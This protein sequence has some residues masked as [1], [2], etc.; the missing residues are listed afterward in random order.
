M[1]DTREPNQILQRA[2]RALDGLPNIHS[3][4]AWT[5]NGHEKRWYL[6]ISIRHGLPATTNIP[7]ITNWIVVPE[8]EFIESG[9]EVYPAING[10]IEAT[11]PHQRYNTVDKENGRRTGRP[12]LTRPSHTLKRMAE[13]NWN[14]E[15]EKFIWRICRLVDW[16]IDAANN[17]LINKSDPFELPDFHGAE[18]CPLTL[19]F[20]EDSIS[21]DFWKKYF[22]SYGTVNLLIHNKTLLLKTFEHQAFISHSNE[23]D[24]IEPNFSYHGKA[25]WVLLKDI[26]ILDPW[27]AP[28][29]FG[30]LR[31][32]LALS[33]LDLENIISKFSNRDFRSFRNGKPLL[34]IIGFPIPEKIG[35]KPSTIHWQA[36]FLPELTTEKQKGFRKESLSLRDKQLCFKNDSQVAWLRSE[37]WTKNNL[38][39]RG[40]LPE[41]MRQKK[42]TIIGAGS[43]G[44]TFTE[45]LVRAGF[46][47]LILVDGDKFRASNASRHVLNLGHVGKPKVEALK[48]RLELIRPGIEIKTYYSFITAIDKSGLEDINSS[49]FIIDITGNSEVLAWADRSLKKSDSLFISLSFGYAAQK[50]FC[51]VSESQNLDVK[52]FNSLIN[53]WL[54]HER[55]TVPKDAD[56]PREGI[57]CWS[58]VFPARADDVWIFASTAI[59]WFQNFSREIEKESLP[60]LD[61]FEQKKS[62]DEFEGI[63]R[64]N[65][66]PQD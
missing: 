42:V 60:R 40:A 33:N 44:S 16:I 45:L 59:K 35:D 52:K 57:G 46:E 30:E 51:F 41:A 39:T 29:N 20:Q 64:A 43:L 21:F 55:K 47:N 58:V 3:I 18:I 23:W 13:E 38:M 7:E 1:L 36:V 62:G 34:L 5:W 49:S 25:I 28:N 22:N 6:P 50:L 31:D 63:G 53:P 9:I 17:N 4:G 2:R 15:S 37:N 14:N 27:K 61:V 56:L 26:P 66:P 48:S 11:L 32:I 8:D 24:S 54:F 10:A 19:A 12:C 65:P